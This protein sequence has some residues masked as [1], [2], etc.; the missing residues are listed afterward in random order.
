MYPRMSQIY[1]ELPGDIDIGRD[2]GLCFH[3]VIEKRLTGDIV[4]VG[5]VFHDITVTTE[6]MDHATEY[7]REA[8]SWGCELHV[9]E[10]ISGDVIHPECGGTPD[11][12]GYVPGLLR[13]LDAKYGHRHVEVYEHEQLLIYI[14]S[15]LEKLGIN[16]LMDQYTWVEI[17]VYQ[18]R[19]YDR[20]GHFRRWRVLA[21][22]LRG[23]FNWLRGRAARTEA[24]DAKCVT[25][26]HCLDCSAR[27]A[28]KAAQHAG[29][30]AMDLAQLP[31]PNDLPSEAIGAELDRIE[32]AM[33]MLKARQTG[34]EAQAM[35]NINNGAQIPGWD[36]ERGQGRLY[37][38]DPKKAEALANLYG[39]SIMNDPEPMTPT[40]VISKHKELAPF[41]PQLANRP[42]GAPKLVRFNMTHM[43]K[44]Y[45]S[46]KDK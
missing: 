18:P 38:I 46:V 40:Q 15:I 25:G 6:M 41:V 29:A 20:E 2:E 43:K 19:C 4:Q 24:A 12:W 8:L 9:E 35:F 31:M 32:W 44:L 7:V 10:S 22:D 5:D 27:H 33:S 26:S 45:E 28:C 11:V 36:I 1:P 42:L 21:S 3:K 16:G 23:N 30:V 13:L 14:A 17:I 34:L 37:W 39:L